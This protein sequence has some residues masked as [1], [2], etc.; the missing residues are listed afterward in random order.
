MPFVVPA[1]VG[2]DLEEL[3]LDGLALNDTILRLLEL[4]CPPPRQRQEWIGAADSEAQL[5]VR[6]PLHENREITCRIQVAPAGDMDGALNRIGEI[7]DKLQK[8]SKNPNGIALTWSPAGST[9][10]VTFDVLSGEIT[11]LPIDWASGWLAKAPTVTVVLKAKPYWRGVE[12]LTATASSST[13]FVTMELVNNSGDVSG[14]GKLIVIDTATQSRR[15]VE[16]GLEGPGTYNAATSLLIDSDSMVTAGFSGAG[17]VLAGAYDPNALGNNAVGGITLTAPQAIV[18]LGTLSHVG[19]FRVKCRMM[20]NVTGTKVR[21]AWQVADGPFSANPW[22]ESP[23]PDTSGGFSVWGEVDLGTVT[24][25]AVLSG[26]QKWTGRIEAYTVN[27]GEVYIDYLTLVPVTDGYGKA[28]ATYTYSPGVV[29][30]Y[31]YFTGTTAGVAL[32]ARVA[33]S[34]GT[35]ATSGSATDFAF[36]DDFFGEQV[37]RSTVS[38]ASARYAIL[39]ATAY[40]DSE[41]AVLIQTQATTTTA[42]GLIARWVDASNHLRGYIYQE[43]NTTTGIIGTYLRLVQVVAGV[44]T[45]LVSA[46]VPTLPLSTSGAVLR[47]IV[48]AS[49]T[50]ILQAVD[51]FQ[52]ATLG[53]AVS[54]SSALATGGTLASGKPGIYD[55]NPSAVAASRFYDNFTLATPVAEPIA[56]YSSRNMQVRHDDVFRQDSTG[57]YVGRPQSYRGSRFTVPVGTSRVLVKARRADIDAVADANVT[58]AT[59]IQVGVTPRGLVVPRG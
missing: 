19:S 27:G 24:I 57:V 4:S 43:K 45:T 6:N 29:V 26:S 11:D 32:N 40:T 42:Q 20:T 7:L 48:Y 2:T 47:L 44:A 34:G 8:A 1:S 30:G 33:P 38:D 53:L 13:P 25:P 28:R 10:T 56:I 5:L 58:D 21:L 39:G 22:V 49:G 36:A 23:V 16:W 18:G 37:K 12:V 15:H 9:R 50:A 54:S 3:V 55:Y 51:T 46:V 35:W 41:V 59:Q 17:V 14:D 52:T 31:D